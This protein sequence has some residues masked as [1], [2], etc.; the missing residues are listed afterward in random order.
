MSTCKKW[1]LGLV[2]AVVMLN[3][4]SVVHAKSNVTYSGP[5]GEFIFSPGSEQSPTD[6]FSSFKNVMPG[7]SLT[8]Q[9]VIKNDV[10]KD[11]KIKVYLRSLGAQK[12]SDDFLSQMKLTVRQADKSELFAAPSNETAQ[13]SEWVCLGTIYSGGEITLDVTLDVP[14]TLDKQYNNAEGFVDWEFMVE[15]YPVESTDPRPSTGDY[16]NV[17]LYAGVALFSLTVVLWMLLKKKE[18]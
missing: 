9:I 3:L 12:D 18:Q 10:S 16:V 11:V 8:E 15:E 17:K 6:L 7:D 4:S 14:I 1:I 2:F 5:S 13:L